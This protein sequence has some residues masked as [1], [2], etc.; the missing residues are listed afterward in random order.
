M[1]VPSRILGL[2][3]GLNTTGYALIDSSV[4]GVRLV[5]AGVIKPTVKRET[6]DMAQRLRRL[7]DGVMEIITQFKPDA[8]SVEQLYAHYEHPRTAIL[9]GHARGVIL[10]AAGMND[11]PVT[12]YAATQIKKAITGSGRAGKDQMQM[13]MLR[14]FRLTEMPEPHDVADALAIALCH[15]YLRG[16]P[17]DRPDITTGLRV[18]LP[19]E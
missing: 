11:I 7:Y 17:N 15:H 5:E 10:L 16:T 2:D 1:S 14:E 4:S 12:G 19:V 8:L 6:A 18:R 13:A 9:M 3:P